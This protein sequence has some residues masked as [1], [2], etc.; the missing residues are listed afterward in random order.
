[1][2]NA[3]TTALGALNANA[4]GLNIVS[5]NLANLNTTGF[6]KEVAQFHDLMA[7]AFRQSGQGAVQTSGGNLD[8]AIQGDG[9]FVVRDSSGAEM[10]TR[11]GNCRLDANGTLLTATGERVQGWS[12]KDGVVDAGG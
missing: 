5:N 10:Y 1:M 11:A 12:A 4:T 8:A 3:F 2:F 6:K 9:F 7:E